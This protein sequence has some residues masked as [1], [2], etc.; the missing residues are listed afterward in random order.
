MMKGR[1][2]ARGYSSGTD[3]NGRLHECDTFTCRHCQKIVDVPAFGR[4]EDVGGLCYTCMGCICPACVD[5]ATCDPID[6]KIKRAE[7]AYHARRSYA[8]AW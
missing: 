4:P 3:G 8:G 5:R 2:R 1:F 7:A 6:E